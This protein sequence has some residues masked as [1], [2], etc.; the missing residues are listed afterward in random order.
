MEKE[1]LFRFIGME[2]LQFATFEENYSENDADV[3]ISNNFQFSYNYEDNTV[4]CVV[5]TVFVQELE[6]LLKSE[7][8]AYFYI[9]KESADQLIKSNSFSAPTELLTQFA[10]LTYG[11]LRGV[12]FTKTIGS[13]LNQ[14][15]LPPND[16]GAIFQDKQ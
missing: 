3:E 9:E 4:K 8:A 14:I 2:I 11:S 15:I 12:I 7:L 5:S 10:S 6:V 1:I 13:P 16:I